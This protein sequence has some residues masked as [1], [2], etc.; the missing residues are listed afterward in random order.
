MER[1]S[2]TSLQLVSL[3]DRL[4]PVTIF[5]LDNSGANL[6]QFDSEAPGTITQSLP[7]TAGIGDSLQAIDFRPAT[8]QLYGLGV[9]T[10][11]GAASLG[12]IYVIDPRTGF[13]MPL[14]S[15]FSLG[16]STTYDIDFNPTVDRI[17]VVTD[18]DTNLRVDPNNGS[19]INDGTLSFAPGDRNFGTN[20]NIAGVAYVNNTPSATATQLFGIDSQL[21]QLVTISPANDGTLITVNPLSVR[22]NS[23][24]GFDVGA[25][26][27]AYVALGN[28][29]QVPQPGQPQSSFYTINLSNGQLQLLGQINTPQEVR[30]IAVSPTNAGASQ[31]PQFG[32]G[33]DTGVDS[34]VRVFNPDRSEL[35]NFSPFPGFT[36]GT[37][38]AVADFNNDGV[39]DTV[40]GT[41][42]GAP[43]QVLVFSG[44]DN[45]LLFRNN[46]FE[47][48]FTGGV[49]VA[50]GDVTN[51]GVADVI[52]T[53]DQGGGPRV[54]IFRGG[55]FSPA[56]DFF[57][58]D[59]PAFRGGA[60][61]AVGDVNGDGTEDLM[62]AAGFGG[63]PRVAVYDGTRI[64]N[65]LA[66]GELPPKLF[67]DFFVFE[68][69][70]RNGVF[71][72]VGDINGDGFAEVIGGGGPGGGPRVRALD[73]KSLLGTTS[74]QVPVANFFAGDLNDRSGVRVVVKNL[75]DDT[76]ADIVTGLGNIGT[77][78]GYLGNTIAPTSNP[79][80]TFFSFN[81]L[82]DN[83][84][85]FVG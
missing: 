55:D 23:I 48:S 32:V 56:A 75:D 76:R 73:G 41:G 25:N 5:A 52:I 4:N 84:G 66:E 85:V 59:D 65:P 38:V 54:R 33:T 63:G 20:P 83:S 24:V 17:R 10:P 16:N 9:S 62:V 1:F 18:A 11:P 19:V 57:G 36:G 82:V 6:L 68:D 74:V 64:T 72:A 51:D 15:Q 47:S 30:D 13:R 43:T 46:P 70:L 53:P 50:A 77:V 71:P 2:S 60:R 67:N 81:P 34:R 37:R 80:A 61:A 7:I 44:K 3:E 79:P 27:K 22:T 21:D 29:V 58:I 12:Q 49:Y 31:V 14:G 39:V 40:V 26:G 8:G 35:A 28:E 42:P 69:T 45:S 78:N